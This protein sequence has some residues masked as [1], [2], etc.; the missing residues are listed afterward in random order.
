[1]FK[2]REREA[3][4]TYTKD[5]ISIKEE[6]EENEKEE[7]IIQVRRTGSPQLVINNAYTI[8]LIKRAL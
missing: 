6:E 8:M 4:E 1:M 3:L 7:E 5:K 2:N